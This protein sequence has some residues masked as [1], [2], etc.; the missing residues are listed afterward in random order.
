ME[1]VKIENTEDSNIKAES[2]TIDSKPPVLI[3]SYITDTTPG[4]DL[5]R[6]ILEGFTVDDFKLLDHS[7]VI[8]LFHGHPRTYITLFLRK[9]TFEFK[10]YEHSDDE[11]NVWT[12][13]TRPG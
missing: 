5:L 12:V 8:D 3:T 10:R 6:K 2:K 9:N 4:K 11:D 13:F 7:D 1:D